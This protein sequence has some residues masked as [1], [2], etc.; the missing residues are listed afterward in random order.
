MKEKTNLCKIRFR[1]P[2]TY[3]FI[4][5]MVVANIIII[6]LNSKYYSSY[7]VA[8][9]SFISNTY[10]KSAFKEIASIIKTFQYHF[11]TLFLSLYI[12]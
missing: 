12:M 6:K 1:K 9:E 7:N 4:F 11:Q 10:L 3:N 5:N 8:L 2:N